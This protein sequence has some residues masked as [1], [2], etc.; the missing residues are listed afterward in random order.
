[1]LTKISLFLFTTLWL[2]VLAVKAQNVGIGTNNPNPSAMLEVSSTDKG[3]LTPRMTT[4]QRIA[5]P[6]PANGLLVYDI[7]STCFAYHVGGTWY[8]L[9]GTIKANNDTK[10]FTTQKDSSI[11]GNFTFTTNVGSILP[12]IN[13]LPGNVPI[14]GIVDDANSAAYAL[15]FTFTFD[16][17]P[18]THISATSN[19]FVKL[20][21]NA[22]GTILGSAFLNDLNL[23]NNIPILAPWWDDLNMISPDGGVWL[24]TEG[25]APNRIFTVEYICKKYNVVGATNNLRFRVSLAEADQSIQFTYFQTGDAGS[26]SVGMRSEDLEYSTVNVATNTA[27]GTTIFQ[28]NSDIPT[29]GRYYKWQQTP[30]AISSISV[31]SPFPFQQLKIEGDLIV[32]N[33]LSV[34]GKIE[35]E[36]IIYP[37]LNL[38]WTTSTSSPFGYY[39]DKENR[40][41]LS[42]TVNRPNGSLVNTIFVLP[43]GYTPLYSSLYNVVNNYSGLGAITIDANGNISVNS[44]ADGSFSLD[45]VSFRAK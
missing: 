35:N 28:N 31:T 32:N 22:S 29:P 19:G 16:S 34:K 42:G 21:P 11:V 8:F 40:V 14:L 7:D 20:L 13:T 12:P 9:K 41:H 5:L 24:L 6:I 44:G 30:T 26:V 25:N 1:M 43:F 4:A 10:I 33:N 17:K 36:A 27:S 2:S 39:K 38:T 18:Y 3:M 15:P 45:G 23:T 37:T